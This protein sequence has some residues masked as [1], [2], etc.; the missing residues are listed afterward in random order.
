LIVRSTRPL[1]AETPVEVFDRFLTPN[2]LFFIRSHFGAPAIGLSPWRLEI[3][4][5]V[6]RPLGLSI[7]D[8]KRETI[9]FP[10]VLQ[11][12]G[13]GRA[14]HSPT[15]PGV[16]WEKGAVGNAE[17]SGVR[18]VDWLRRSGIKPGAA[19]VQFEG[20]DDPPNPRTPAFH[21]SLPIARALD[22]STILATSMNGEALPTLHGGPVRLVVP[23]WSGNH[24]IKWVR[25]ITVSREE[26]PGF[27]MRNG[28]KIPKVPTPPGVEPKPEDLVPVTTLN[29]KSLIARPV[30]GANLPAGKVEVKGV[31]WTGEGVV[32]KVEIETSTGA[33]WRP[34]TLLGDPIPGAW[35]PWTFAWD[36]RPGRHALRVRATDSNGQ[37]QPE[38]SPWNKSGYLWNGIDRVTC[39][40]R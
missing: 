17:W 15:V 34:A 12:S 16:A 7:E 6:D 24:W 35:R 14:F 18:L 1:D 38:V 32:T 8:L 4:G 33:G 13:N 39:E 5:L 23:G 28:Y 21:R 19:H 2:R 22:P 37:V 31:A 27:Y 20:A 40:I 26:S 29:V 3:G 11:C 9:T 10:A 36:A 25:K 30:E